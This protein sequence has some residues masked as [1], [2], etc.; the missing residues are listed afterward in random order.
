M[1]HIPQFDGV[2]EQ[3]AA[4]LE[5]PATDAAKVENFFLR[6]FD[7]QEGQVV[8]PSHEEDRTNNSLSFP[9]SSH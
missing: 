8:D 5:P 3:E 1:P 2:P 7:P 9:Q 6:C 4:S